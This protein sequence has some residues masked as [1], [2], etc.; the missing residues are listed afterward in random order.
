VRLETEEDV[1]DGA[2]L[3]RVVRGVRVSHEVAARAENLHTVLP[4]RPEM[5]VAR[6]QVDL[7]TTPVQCS[8]PV[9]ADRS[10]PDDCNSHGDS[11]SVV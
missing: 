11:L 2:D 9:G 1:I 3:G 5:L 10:G 8:T 4:H 7:R 6:D